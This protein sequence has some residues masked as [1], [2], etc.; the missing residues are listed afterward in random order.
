MTAAQC[1]LSCP[2]RFFRQE[3]PYREKSTPLVFRGFAKRNRGRRP[4]NEKRAPTM[5]VCQA[6]KRRRQ[7][8]LR[9]QKCPRKAR[10]FFRLVSYRDQKDFFDKSNLTETSQ[11]RSFFVVS[12]SEIADDCRRNEKRAPARA[13][14]DTLLRGVV[15][16][17]G[18]PL[19]TSCRD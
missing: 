8:P 18:R 14:A 12:R 3:Q 7:M 11:P 19:T 9:L 15:P 4:R 17:F 10:A 2:K 1:V 5:S 6:A 16:R 13:P